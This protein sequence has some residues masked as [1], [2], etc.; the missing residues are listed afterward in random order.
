[1]SQFTPGTSDTQPF[2][3]TIGDIGVTSAYVVTPNGTAPL[4]GSRWIASDMTVIEQ[5]IPPVAIVLAVVFALF[6]LLGLLFL[7]MKE[8]VVH[9]YVQVSVSS[10][11]LLHTTQIP[12]NHAEQVQYVRALV[13]QAQALAAQAPDLA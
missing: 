11:N 10:G 12:V 9:G 4:K 1:M 6:C 8:T 5:R 13:A 7:L 3:L 2:V